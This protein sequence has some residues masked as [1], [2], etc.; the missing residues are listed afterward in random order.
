MCFNPMCDESGGMVDMVM[1][2]KRCNYFEA[3]RIIDSAHAGDSFK[4]SLRDKK[5]HEP[6]VIE[7]EKVEEWHSNLLSHQEPLDYILGRHITME[8]IE[9]FKLGYSVKA[10][11]LVTPVFSE[12]GICVGG[13]GRGVREKVF[14]NIPGTQT[15]KSLFNIQNAKKHSTVVIVESN[16]DAIRV[17][18]AGFPG[19][20]ATCGGNFSEDHLQQMAYYFDKVIIMTDVDGKKIVPDCRKCYKSGNRYCVGHDAGRDLGAKIA[21]QCARAGLA[22]RWAYDEKCGTIYP[23][24]AKDAGDMTDE[25]IRNCINNSISNFE[26]QTL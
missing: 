23:N 18:Q 22:V 25:Q 20:V 14:K 17:H 12:Q 16:F 2:L 7:A 6:L 24:G 5:R 21:K 15:S 1:G 10:N 4:V 26:Y 3:I 19:V 11:L 13:I 9:Y 8:S